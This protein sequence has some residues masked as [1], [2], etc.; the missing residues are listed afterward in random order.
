[1]M[2]ELKIITQFAAAHQI[3]GIEGG[4][5]RLHGHN[6]KVEVFVSGD[7]LD[8]NGLLIDFRVMKDKTEALMEELDH[9]FLNELEP[10]ITLNPS[11]ENVSR[12]V[13]EALSRQLNTDTIRISKITV[14]ESDSACASYTEP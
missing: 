13:Y 1:M 14:W 8:E 7:K 9:R 2:Y 12:Y 6:W 5:E 10:F 3:R 11:S 4:C